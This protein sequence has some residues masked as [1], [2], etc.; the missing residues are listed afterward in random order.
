MSDIQLRPSGYA[1]TSHPQ[2]ISD[3]PP[4]WLSLFHVLR[5]R[6][7]TPWGE[8]KGGRLVCRDAACMR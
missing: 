6:A 3:F 7:P 4:I 1:V 5:S 8:E 2:K